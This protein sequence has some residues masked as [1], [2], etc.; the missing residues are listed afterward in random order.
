MYR[1]IQDLNCLREATFYCCRAKL[2]EWNNLRHCFLS[3]VDQVCGKTKV[4]RVRHNQTWR[5]NGTVND[6]V[7]EKQ[8]NGTSGN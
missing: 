7:K 5:W 6:V 4:G 8:K 2:M 3:G 1:G